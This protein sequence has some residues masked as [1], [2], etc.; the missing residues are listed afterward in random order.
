M[1][2]S[3]DRNEMSTF[4]LYG[5]DTDIL[6][7]VGYQEALHLFI[8]FFLRLKSWVLDV[9]ILHHRTFMVLVIAILCRVI[10]ASS[11][12]RSIGSF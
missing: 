6:D 9:K 12:E 7:K 1:D 2:L 11:V 3:G 8:R 10:S 5:C 4:A